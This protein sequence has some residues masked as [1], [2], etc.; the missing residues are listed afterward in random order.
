[1]ESSHSRVAAA[2]S[3]AGVREGCACALAFG[4]G[5]ASGVKGA[6]GGSGG[7][8]ARAGLGISGA[9]GSCGNPVLVRISKLKT[10]AKPL[11]GST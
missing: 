11:I 1:M 7:G 4:V 3:N 10:N 2:G 6:A 9:V 8:L 5:K